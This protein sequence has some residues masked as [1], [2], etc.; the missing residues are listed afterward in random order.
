MVWVRIAWGHVDFCCSFKQWISQEYYH[1]IWKSK[2]RWH[3]SFK[4]IGYCVVHHRDLA[5]RVRCKLVW[6]GWTT[7]QLMDVWNPWTVNRAD[8]SMGPMK[9]IYWSHKHGGW[10]LV[11]LYKKGGRQPSIK[12]NTFRTCVNVLICLFSASSACLQFEDH[13]QQ[14]IITLNFYLEPVNILYFGA[15]T[16]QKKD[17]SNQKTLVKYRSLVYISIILF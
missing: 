12:L 4:S 15:S 14:K 2:G 7:K 11:H 10:D 16:L 8:T 17:L 13:Q 5:T 9:V 6:T 3:V 1:E